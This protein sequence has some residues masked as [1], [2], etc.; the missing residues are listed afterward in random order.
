MP[1]S[2]GDQ[3]F[4]SMG[5]HENHS[6]KKLWSKYESE[7]LL[8]APWS[9]SWPNLRCPPTLSYEP[10]Q[11]HSLGSLPPFHSIGGATRFISSAQLSPSKQGVWYYILIFFNQTISCCSILASFGENMTPR[12]Y[13]WFSLESP[14]YARVLY[15][16]RTSCWNRYLLWAINLFYQGLHLSGE[17]QLS[18][19]L[20]DYCHKILWEVYW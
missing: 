9:P 1:P 7:V 8:L 2:L 3:Q 17:G 4:H 10:T 13:C 19:P 11:F 20:L 14:F 16:S 12:W 6:N 18:Y 5:S 15:F